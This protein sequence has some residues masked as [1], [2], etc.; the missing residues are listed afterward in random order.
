M[1]ERQFEKKKHAHNDDWT[2]K[3][4]GR[5]FEYYKS[6]SLLTILFFFFMSL[7]GRL[8]NQIGRIILF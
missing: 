7:V 4:T 3:T 5:S 8:R 1:A 2:I 6:I